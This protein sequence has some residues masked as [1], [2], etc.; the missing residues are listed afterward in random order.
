MQFLPCFTNPGSHLHICFPLRLILQEEPFAHTKSQVVAAKQIRAETSH[1]L[2][3][4]NE[5]LAFI[6]QPT[7]QQAATAQAHLGIG[8]IGSNRRDGNA[9]KEG[10]TSS[11]FFVWCFLG[12]ESNPVETEFKFPSNQ[13]SVDDIFEVSEATSDRGDQPKQNSISSDNC[14]V[15]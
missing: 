12:Y 5:I 7:F 10:E 4:R 13:T 8:T 1:G 6:G 14:W 9:R 3:T 11:H 15:K 2:K